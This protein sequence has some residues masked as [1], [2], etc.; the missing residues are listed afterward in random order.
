MILQRSW[1][2]VEDLV[3]VLMVMFRFTDDALNRSMYWPSVRAEGDPYHE[4]ATIAPT[5]I[6]LHASGAEVER[7]LTLQENIQGIHGISYGTET[8][9]ARLVL[10]KTR[11]SDPT[12]SDDEDD[13]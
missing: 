8:R 13:F 11:W 5:F 7:T 12:P 9:H 1:K 3:E 6:S 10:H 4:L 2:L